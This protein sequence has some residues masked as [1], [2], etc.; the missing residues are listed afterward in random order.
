MGFFDSLK[1]AFEIAEDLVKPSEQNVNASV[2]AANTADNGILAS[3]STPAK[4]SVK[5]ETT[6]FGGD[7]GDDEFSVSFMLSGDFVE[8]NSHCELDPAF[9]YE[10]NSSEDYTE[11]KEGV[12]KIFIGPI[13]SVY[14]AA[15]RFEE[16]GAPVG[17]DFESIGNGTFLF[18]AMFDYCGDAMYAYVFAAGTTQE[19]N[20][21]ALTYD[22]KF[23]GTVLEK[24]LKAALDEAASTYSE[25]KQ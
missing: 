25:I 17:T 20:V 19:H 10:P 12:P 2:K 16:D 22:R 18:K 3:G 6:F 11:Y 24:K 9:L 15:I 7:E 23:E 14:D 4:P 8:F 21:L 1:K 13:N 5:R